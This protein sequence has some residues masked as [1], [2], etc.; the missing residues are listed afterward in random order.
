M[1]M[2]WLKRGLRTPL[3]C[4][5]AAPI[6]ARDCH[7]YVPQI[8]ERKCMHTTYTARAPDIGWH[9]KYMHECITYYTAIKHASGRVTHPVRLA[10]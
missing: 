5:C 9:N 7:N 4:A 2:I 8:V 6:H 10:A 3:D 1:H